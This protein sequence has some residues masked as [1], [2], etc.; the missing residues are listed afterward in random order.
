LEDPSLIIPIEGLKTGITY[1]EEEADLW[2]DGNIGH[3]RP[4]SNQVFEADCEN[5]GWENTS[6]IKTIFKTFYFIMV[7]I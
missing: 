5:I 3:A 7:F 6:S 2:Y 4:I 1:S